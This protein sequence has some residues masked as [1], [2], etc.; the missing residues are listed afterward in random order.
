MTR[1][2]EGQDSQDVARAKARG[3]EDQGDDGGSEEEG[4]K[5]AGSL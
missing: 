1:G 2:Q 4:G 5:K 3:E